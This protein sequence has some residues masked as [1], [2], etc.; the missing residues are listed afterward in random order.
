M[1]ACEVT[2]QGFSVTFR[3][4]QVSCTNIIGIFHRERSAGPVLPPVLLGTHYD[5]RVRAD[6]EKNPRFSEIPIPGA[7]DGGSGTAI[8]LHLLPRLAERGLPRDIAVAFFDAEDMGNIDGKD[9]ALGAAWLADHPV[10]GFI[11]AEAIV[12][13]MVG[14][15]GMVLDIDANILAHAPSRQLTARLFRGGWD[16][17]WEPFTG[18]KSNR[19][20]YIIS[21]HTPFARKG[22]AAAILIDIDY[23]EWHT[24]ADLPDAM[25]AA[26]LG[27]IEAALWLYL[28]R[29][30][31]EARRDSSANAGP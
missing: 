10:S 15:K 4:E 27:I 21:D 13:D 22:T 7:N 12:L 25:S 8:L 11:P 16:Q 29:P 19:V 17:G 9:F 5:T 28:S 18:E 6:R 26:S 20:K 23:P 30:E 14:G 2:M 24:Q 3:G 1:H 31:E